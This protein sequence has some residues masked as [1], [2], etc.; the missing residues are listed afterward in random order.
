MYFGYFV[1]I[2]YSETGIFWK[3]IVLIMVGAF[4]R[5][6]NKSITSYRNLDVILRRI[7]RCF[8]KYSPLSGTLYLQRNDEIH[9]SL[10][11][12]GFC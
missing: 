4:Q 10:T 9:I 5:N 12:A 6:F 2:H 3:C 8:E 1:G 11:S 7:T